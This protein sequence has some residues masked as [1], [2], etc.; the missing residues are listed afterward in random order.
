[1]LRENI[2]L[3][4]PC[5]FDLYGLPSRRDFPG[6]RNLGAA[7]AYTFYIR[8]QDTYQ[9]FQSLPTFLALPF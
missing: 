2:D 8:Q 7:E 3:V 5:S 1:M 4:F 9:H 6:W